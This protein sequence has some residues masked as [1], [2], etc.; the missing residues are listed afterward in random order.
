MIAKIIPLARDRTQSLV[1]SR[2]KPHLNIFGDFLL[3]ESWKHLVA[4]PSHPIYVI[5]CSG[6]CVH[7]S[8][9]L[10]SNHEE[11]L[12]MVVTGSPGKTPNSFS[13][14]PGERA[15]SSPLNSF[16][17]E[18]GG[19]QPELAVLCLAVSPVPPPL[20]TV[21]GLASCIASRSCLHALCQLLPF[22][23]LRVKVDRPIVSERKTLDGRR[24]YFK[25]SQEGVSQNVP[26]FFFLLGCFFSMVPMTE[27]VNC[28]CSFNMINNRHF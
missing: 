6:E 11:Q 3:H 22:Q 27:K 18:Q 26:G 8:S 9:L 13:S 28:L 10:R 7:S 15:L 5:F 24:S 4:I 17:R 2:A 20:L 16:L 12:Q 14:V 1:R 23:Q 25:G 21:L 19:L